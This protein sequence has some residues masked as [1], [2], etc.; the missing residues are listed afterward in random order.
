MSNSK[1]TRNSSTNIRRNFNPKKFEIKKKRFDIRKGRKYKTVSFSTHKKISIYQKKDKSK[2]QKISFFKKKKLKENK[3]SNSL[4]NNNYQSSKN[5]MSPIK[6]RR[7]GTISINSFKNLN[8]M[9]NSISKAKLLN[10]SIV[11]SNRLS[12]IPSINLDKDELEMSN[13]IFNEF[14][15]QFQ[16]NDLD[17]LKNYGS[18]KNLEEDIESQNEEMFQK[19]KIL[20]DKEST[21]I[22]NEKQRE[23][24]LIMKN[25]LDCDTSKEGIF[26]LKEKY[27]L[28]DEFGENL[29]EMN[30]F[31]FQQTEQNQRKLEQDLIKIKTK[32]DEIDTFLDEMYEEL[33]ITNE[34]DLQNL[35]SSQNNLNQSYTIYDNKALEFEKKQKKKNERKTEFFRQESCE[36]GIKQ[37]IN[38]LISNSGKREFIRTKE[39]LKKTT[40]SKLL[41]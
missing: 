26:S 10:K 32:N 27:K 34:K 33:I 37:F 36:E 31:D 41:K 14:V 20:E 9:N 15:Q 23:N 21:L 35:C 3:S 5:I 19:L 17:I 29:K 22:Q 24:S 40:E 2:E 4:M 39:Y 16:L 30:I 12:N 1:M 6:M 11:N 8:G 25:N 13:E 38:K 18:S 28:D 7:N